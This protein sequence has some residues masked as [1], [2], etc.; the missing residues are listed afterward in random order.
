[1]KINGFKRVRSLYNYNASILLN[2]GLLKKKKVNL[3]KKI[4]LIALVYKLH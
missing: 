4:A 3:L 1:M 2:Q